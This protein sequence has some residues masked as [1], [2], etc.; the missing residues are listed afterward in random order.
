MSE[1][2][3]MFDYIIKD[4]KQYH[5]LTDEEIQRND[6]IFILFCDCPYGF[7]YPDK[8]EIKTITPKQKSRLRFILKQTEEEV[9]KVLALKHAW[10]ISQ[11]N[12]LDRTEWEEYQTNL[13]RYFE[14]EQARL[15]KWY[16]VIDDLGELRR[17]LN[18][19]LT[20]VDA[21]CENCR[22]GGNLFYIHI[23]PCFW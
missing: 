13:L 10:E 16:R 19:S 7:E 1:E 5:S 14:R 23:F 18:S 12:S 9:N 2:R 15:A 22:I 21:G 17:T 4:L 11:N 8:K 3:D 20:N 6:Q